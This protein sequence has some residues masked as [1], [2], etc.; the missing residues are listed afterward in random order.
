MAGKFE[1]Y[2]DKGGE[3]RFRLKAGNGQAILAS[4]GYKT[5]ASCKNGVAS[6]MKN[7]PTEARYERKQTAS[8]KRTCS[9]LPPPMARLCRKRAA[10]EKVV[11]GGGCGFNAQHD[12]LHNGPLAKAQVPVHIRRHFFEPRVARR[13]Y[14]VGGKQ[15]GG[16]SAKLHAFHFPAA[17]ML[18]AVRGREGH[19]AAISAFHRPISLAV[20]PAMSMACSAA[21]LS[22]SQCVASSR[23]QGRSL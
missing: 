10:F 8:G 16:I 23:Y 5:K 18:A 6:V 14:V 11:Q 7:A 4:E 12:R 20:M 1:I 22:N 9:T 15:Q 21:R 2:Q 13:R 19:A 3:F 17:A